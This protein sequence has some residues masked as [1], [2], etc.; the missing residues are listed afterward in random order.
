LDRRRLVAGLKIARRIAARHSNLGR[1]GGG[2]FNISPGEIESVL[3]LHPAIAEIAVAGLPD[4]RPG[5]SGSS[6]HQCLH[7]DV[8][9]LL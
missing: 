5:A 2:V 9:L 4:E 6:F 1:Q 8:S 3:S 7:R